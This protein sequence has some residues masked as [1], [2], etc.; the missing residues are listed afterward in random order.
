[1]ASSP[2][3]TRARRWGK[4]RKVVAGVSRAELA[5][6]RS[7]EALRKGLDR[8]RKQRCPFCEH[9]LSRNEWDPHIDRHMLAQEERQRRPGAPPDPPPGRANPDKE[10]ERRR[11]RSA[12]MPDPRP[13]TPKKPDLPGPDHAAATAAWEKRIKETEAFMAGRTTSAPGPISGSSQQ[14]ARAFQAWGADIP[15][16]RAD[17]EAHLL[18]MTGAMGI[19]A[20][21]VREWTQ[22]AIIGQRLHPAIARPLD[23]AATALEEDRMDFTRAYQILLRIYRNRIEHEEQDGPKP[24]EEFWKD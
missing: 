9:M 2:S 24:A 11:R 21:A 14:L 16:K 6:R 23:S 22:Q 7:L 5:R 8:G 19:G 4:T 3:K 10:A 12:R 1:M 18:G 20:Q 13:K 15:S 17:I